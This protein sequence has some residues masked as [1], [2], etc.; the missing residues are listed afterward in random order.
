MQKGEGGGEWRR[1]LVANRLSRDEEERGVQD[2]DADPVQGDG[3]HG[4]WLL[5]C[6]SIPIRA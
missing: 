6:A 4:R 2:G 1:N 5:G 3:E